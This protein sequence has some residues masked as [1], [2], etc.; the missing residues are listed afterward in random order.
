MAIIIKAGCGN[1]IERPAAS[2]RSTDDIGPAI[3]AALGASPDNSE[4]IVD[5]Q[6]MKGRSATATSCSFARGRPEGLN[7]F[8]RVAYGYP[9]R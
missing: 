1:Q 3:F 2:I 6:P 9:A 8:D 7:P 5:G 4:F